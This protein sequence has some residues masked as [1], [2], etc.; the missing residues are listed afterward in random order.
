MANSYAQKLEFIVDD[1]PADTFAVFRMSGREAISEM[2]RFE[3]D[4]VSDDPNL[5]LDA[6]AGKDATLTVTRL[7]QTRKV[8]G[9]LESIELHAATPRSHYIYKAVLVPRLQ[10]LELS[11]QNQIHGTAVPVSVREV[12]T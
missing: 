6:L 8:H 2:F 10:R 7:E 1:Q 12:L 11:R 5:S 9:M 4:L 3:V